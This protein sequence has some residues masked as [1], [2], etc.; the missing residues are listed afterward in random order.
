MLLAWFWLREG[1]GFR[2]KKEKRMTEFMV[3]IVVE[4]VLIS[5]KDG[6]DCVE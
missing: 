3:S 5:M 2:G 1:D 6:R 4:L